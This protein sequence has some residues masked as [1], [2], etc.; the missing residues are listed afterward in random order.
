MFIWFVMNLFFEEGGEWAGEVCVSYV[1][2]VYWRMI[3][4]EFICCL[5]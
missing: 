4:V 1:A 5:L 2:G 3:I